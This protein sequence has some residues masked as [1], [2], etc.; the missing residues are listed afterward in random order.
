MQKKK[1]DGFP[2]S[3][4]VG[5]EVGVWGCSCLVVSIFL[6]RDDL[7]S[8]ETE[9]G[10]KCWK[11]DI[12]IKEKGKITWPEEWELTWDQWLWMHSD[13]IYPVGWWSLAEFATWRQVPW[14]QIDRFIQGRDITIRMWWGKKDLGFGKI[15][16]AIMGIY[17]CTMGEA[18]S[19]G[20]SKG[21]RE[22][23]FHWCLRMAVVEGVQ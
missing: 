19:L 17:W 5:S 12:V 23:I 16:N 18:A 2:C 22:R 14:K 11:F 3:M 7:L 9:V 4:F 8:E 15:I 20:E 10:R 1:G 6:W 13:A 21:V